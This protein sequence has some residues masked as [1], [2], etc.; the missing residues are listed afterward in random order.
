MKKVTTLLFITYLTLN[1]FGQA[2]KTPTEYTYDANGN[3][4]KATIIYLVKTM[5]ALVTEFDTL[6]T[7]SVKSKEPSILPTEVWEGLDT[8]QTPKHGW[9]PK[10]VE[11]L[12]GYSLILYPNPNHGQVIVEFNN[13]LNEQISYSESKIE[14]FDLQGKSVLK[15][16]KLQKYNNIDLSALPNG[17]FILR[18]YALS[19]TKEYKIIKK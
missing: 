16:T 11:R 15:M 4:T 14:I 13:S 7:E 1:S 8:A 10:Y 12:T 2:I 18:V 19:Q 5:S 9:D 17:T 3:R 6:T